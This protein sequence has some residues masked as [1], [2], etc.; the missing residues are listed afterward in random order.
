[1][2]TNKMSIRAIIFFLAALF[3]V[4]A[5]AA[6]AG[7]SGQY[8]VNLRIEPAVPSAGQ[9][10]TLVADGGGCDLFGVDDPLAREIS[11]LQNTIQV[12]VRYIYSLGPCPVPPT[13]TDGTSAHFHQDPIASNFTEKT[14]CIFRARCSRPSISPL[15]PHQRCHCRRRSHR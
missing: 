14:N 15:R 8:P 5:H 12:D 3:A 9:A 4:A 10:I 11:Q 13:L 1:M 6:V 2:A 7:E